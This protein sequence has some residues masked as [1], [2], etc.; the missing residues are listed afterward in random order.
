MHHVFLRLLKSSNSDNINSCSGI[1]GTNYTPFKRGNLINLAE[2]C[3]YLMNK[4][5][6]ELIKIRSCATFRWFN[7][8]AR[9]F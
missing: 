2:I 6:R 9:F 3:L 1:V 8:L 7:P 4:M 5:R